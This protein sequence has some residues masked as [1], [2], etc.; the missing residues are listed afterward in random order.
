MHAYMYVRDIYTND[1]IEN[2]KFYDFFFCHSRMRKMLP[3]NKF[4]FQVAYGL[5]PLSEM[6]G[7]TNG[8]VPQKSLFSSPVLST[9]VTFMNQS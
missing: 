7:S 6:V 2:F 1:H 3:F 5:L 9:G 4:I 8:G